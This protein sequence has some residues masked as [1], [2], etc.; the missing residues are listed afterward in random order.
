ME[1]KISYIYTMN[2]D[3]RNAVSFLRLRPEGKLSD[4]RVLEKLVKKLGIN[5]ERRSRGKLLS[6]NGKV[7]IKTIQAEIID[8]AQLARKNAEMKDTK[9]YN[10]IKRPTEKGVKLLDK[11]GAFQ[12]FQVRFD[13]PANDLGVLHNELMDF[14]REKKISNTFLILMFEEKGA[15]RLR[16]VSVR[17]IDYG[18]LGALDKYIQNIFAGEVEGSDAVDKDN[19]DLVYDI[20]GVNT[21]SA[22]GLGDERCMLWEIEDIKSK[23]NCG[24]K[25]LEFAVL[26]QNLK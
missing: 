16:F 7:W 20:I 18:T 1:T 26:A 21:F 17:P 12:N 23:G 10:R 5:T 13:N 11:F 6:K 25:C 24:D 14:V 9:I 4:P 19:Y 8:K 2:E 22:E 15:N 3:L